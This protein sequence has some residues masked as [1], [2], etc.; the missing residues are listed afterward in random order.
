ML[1]FSEKHAGEILCTEMEGGVK[2]CLFEMNLD[3]CDDCDEGV[4]F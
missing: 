1:P 4:L 2:W 3:D